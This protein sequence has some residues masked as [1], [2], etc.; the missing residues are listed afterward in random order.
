M[1]LYWTFLWLAGK[2]LPPEAY[3]LYWRTRVGWPWQS[4]YHLVTAEASAE[5][6]LGFLALVLLA[7]LA[8]GLWGAR[9]RRELM[10]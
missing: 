8:A 9:Q 3:Q 7:I 4:L 10:A 5:K 1:G 6:L 2:P